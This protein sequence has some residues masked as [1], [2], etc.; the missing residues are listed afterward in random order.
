MIIRTHRPLVALTTTLFLAVG[1]A[2]ATGAPS[3]RAAVACPPPSPLAQVLQSHGPVVVY[4]NSGAGQSAVDRPT[5]II[6]C[7]KDRRART[8][9]AISVRHEGSRVFRSVSKITISDRAVGYLEQ[10]ESMDLTANMANY[11][12][13]DLRTQ[14]L[15]ACVVVQATGSA[16]EAALHTA[17]A[18]VGGQLQ[19]LP[20]PRGALA[21]INGTHVL[22]YDATGTHTVGHGSALHELTVT[23]T[24]VQWRNG[25][26]AHSAPIG[27]PRPT[28]PNCPGANVAP[29]RPR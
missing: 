8:R 9:L 27:G 20:S 23:A 4:A 10:T 15:T 29:I 18:H 26:E 3:P 22:T 1:A 13:V 5:S 28:P 6:A 21:S 14:R 25:R 12:V 7:A 16:R 11:Q 17:R 2:A 24:R 19:F